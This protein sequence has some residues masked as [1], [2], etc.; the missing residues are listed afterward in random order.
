[1]LFANET[2][3]IVLQIVIMFDCEFKYLGE[4]FWSWCFCYTLLESLLE[5]LLESFDNI[6]AL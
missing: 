3:Q 5:L 2:K 4:F 1:M 6:D